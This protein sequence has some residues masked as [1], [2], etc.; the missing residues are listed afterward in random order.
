M[1][2]NTPLSRILEPLKI[3]VIKSYAVIQGSVRA[4]TMTTLT[5]AIAVA[6]TSLVNTIVSAK[7]ITLVVNGEQT[8]VSTHVNTVDQ[9]LYQQSIEVTASDYISLAGST[10]LKDGQTLVIRQPVSIQLQLGN[11]TQTIQTT[12]A[13]VQSFVKQLGLK[14]VSTNTVSP[15]LNTPITANMIVALNDVKTVVVEEK[16]SV[17][18][19]TVTKQDARLM[20]GRQKVLQS[21]KAG[22]IVTKIEKQYHNGKLISVKEISTTETQKAQNRILSVGTAKRVAIL[23]AN[24]PSE[25]VTAKNGVDFQAKRV[26]SNVTLSAYDAG[27]ESTGK[28]KGQKG[29]GKTRTGTTVTEGRTI[30]VDPDVIPLGWW[31]YIE[32]IGF[33]RAED[34]GSAIQGNR[35]DVYFDS[36]QTALNFGK[37]RGYTV[38]VIGPEK[39]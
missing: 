8:E 1:M 38:Y 6:A 28:V 35:I 11:Q 5:I 10:E 33:R 15:A 13:D 32:G 26:L 23:S 34:T 22:V 37:K 19:E 31:V 9:L 24:S 17:P 3:G 25:T 21:G 7:E 12:A 30:A 14:S 39:P 36:Y 4:K 29:Y 18:F 16:K 27:F 2:E 20:K